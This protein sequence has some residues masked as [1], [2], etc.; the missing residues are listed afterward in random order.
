MTPY[1][2]RGRSRALCRRTS[3]SVQTA[4]S[5]KAPRIVVLCETTPFEHAKR[6]KAASL[7]ATLWRIEDYEHVGV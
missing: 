3:P 6:I 7:E 2:V 5:G 4:A 1:R